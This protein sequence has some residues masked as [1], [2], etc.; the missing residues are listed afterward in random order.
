M[1]FSEVQSFLRKFRSTDTVTPWRFAASQARRVSSAA[2]SDIAGP[3]E[4]CGAFH[5]CVEIE[6]GGI[7]FRDGG[8]GTVIYH[9]RRTHRRACLGIVQTYAGTSAGYEVGFHTVAAQCVHGNLAY[10]VRGEFG[11]I[12]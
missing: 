3:V 5:Y 11:H 6:V 7:G 10:L 2:L 1:A 9:F 12:E 8:V 4:P